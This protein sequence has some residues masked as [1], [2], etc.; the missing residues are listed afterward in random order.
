MRA[1]AGPAMLLVIVAGFM[2]HRGMSSHDA[3]ARDFVESWSS[4]RPTQIT[5]APVIP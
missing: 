3:P 4:R 2:I 5:P 1:L